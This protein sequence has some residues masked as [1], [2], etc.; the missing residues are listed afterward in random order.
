MPSVFF[1]L[2][3]FAVAIKAVVAVVLES[4]VLSVA[5]VA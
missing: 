2:V 5:L 3:E 4:T 1:F